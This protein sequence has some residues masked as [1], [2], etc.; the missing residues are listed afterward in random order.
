MEHYKIPK[1]SLYQFYLKEHNEITQ[2]WSDEDWSNFVS[3]HEERFI[4]YAQD[5]YLQFVEEYNKTLEKK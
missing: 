3:S 1:E 4:D 5:I 2:E